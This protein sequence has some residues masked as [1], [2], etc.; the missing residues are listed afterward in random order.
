MTRKKRDGRRN[1]G[2]PP[3]PNGEA[4]TVVRCPAALLRSMREF[5]ARLEIP[6]AEAW[7]M[8]AQLML[9]TKTFPAGDVDTGDGLAAE[10]DR[11]IRARGAK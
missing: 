1:N 4:Q 9:E 3:T 2:R 11:A 5:A 6:Q 8:A 10:I 7:R